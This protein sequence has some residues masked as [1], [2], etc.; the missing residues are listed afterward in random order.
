[1]SQIY[2]K[3]CMLIEFFNKISFFFKFR[4]HKN[5]NEN[6]GLLFETMKPIVNQK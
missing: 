5:W 4:C 2:L 1:M 3:F 6:N